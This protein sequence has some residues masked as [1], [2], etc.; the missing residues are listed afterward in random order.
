MMLEEFIRTDRMLI[1]E[2]LT[3]NLIDIY[4]KTPVTN[5]MVQEI[6]TVEGITNP[7]TCPHDKYKVT[8][9]VSKMFS[10]YEVAKE[11]QEKTEHMTF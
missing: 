7:Q 10:L 8:A 3:E 1:Q 6:G 2:G 11:I 5:G 9:Y 4:Y